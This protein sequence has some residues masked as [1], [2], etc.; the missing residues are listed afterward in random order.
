VAAPVFARIM[1]GLLRV[2]NIPPSKT[3][4]NFV[5]A[6]KKDSSET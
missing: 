4:E 5:D 1:S 3:V 6:A 2:K